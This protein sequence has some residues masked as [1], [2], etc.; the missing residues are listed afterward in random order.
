M[1]LYE[2]WNGSQ[3]GLVHVN[4]H[5]RLGRRL[6]RLPPERFP[7]TQTPVRYTPL[8]PGLLLSL[9]GRQRC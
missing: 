9:R 5:G 1:D 6:F 8:T 3:S 7:W 2:R 4:H